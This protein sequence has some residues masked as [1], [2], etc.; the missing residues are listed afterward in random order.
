MRLD[1]S[2]HEGVWKVSLR[3]DGRGICFD[4]LIDAVKEKGLYEKI[5]TDPEKVSAIDILVHPGF[6]T[7]KEATDLSGRGVGLDSIHEDIKNIGGELNLD[8]KE[9]EYT[10]FTLSWKKIA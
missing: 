9:H 3:D 7:K 4:K 5:F 6:S 8:S 2:E 1:I 10:E